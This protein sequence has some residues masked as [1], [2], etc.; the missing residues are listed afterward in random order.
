MS[1]I[2]KAVSLILVMKLAFRTAESDKNTIGVSG[3]KIFN[4][5]TRKF[6]S[7]VGGTNLVLEQSTYA[8][9]PN[10]YRDGYLGGYNIESG[11]I[12]VAMFKTGISTSSESSKRG[13]A[14]KK[15]YLPHKYKPSCGKWKRLF[16][17]K[18]AQCHSIEPGG[19]HKQGPNLFG[20]CGRRAGESSHFSYTD[21]M[22]DSGITWNEDTLDQ[23]LQ[24][25]KE[26][27]PGVKMV[28]AGI[29]KKRDRQNLIHYL[30]HC[31]H[32]LLHL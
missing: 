24:N 28:F 6:E 17:Q 19:G 25:P 21:S 2:L 31:I 29:K 14:E 10:T 13:G 5:A 22:K 11:N 26:M 9:E 32:W 15:K 16:R 4:D 23:Y 20:I 12:S 3:S 27:I 8:K 18:A 1:S 30:C 7:A